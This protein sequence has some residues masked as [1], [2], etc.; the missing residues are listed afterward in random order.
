MENILSNNLKV[1]PNP[2]NSSTTIEFP[3]DNN[4]VFKLYIYDVMGCLVRKQDNISTDKL[5]IEKAGLIKGVY[6]IELKSANQSIKTKII[7]E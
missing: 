6:F 4:E 5:V 1:F 3:N 2:F 7:V